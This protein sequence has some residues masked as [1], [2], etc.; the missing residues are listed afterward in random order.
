MSFDFI[1]MVQKGDAAEV[2]R[3]AAIVDVNYQ[4]QLSDGEAHYIGY[5]AMHAAVFHDMSTSKQLTMLPLLV[6]EY[7]ADVD[8][9]WPKVGAPLE[10]AVR[11]SRLSHTDEQQ[12]TAEIQSI[13]NYLI[14]RS[15]VASLKSAMVTATAVCP[16]ARALLATKIPFLYNPT[17]KELDT[18][19]TGSEGFKEQF[20]N[21]GPADSPST[22]EGFRLTTLPSP[23][24]SPA[25]S[26][27]SQALHLMGGFA[28]PGVVTPSSTPAPIFSTTVGTTTYAL[29]ALTS[30]AIITRPTVEAKSSTVPTDAKAEMQQP[31]LMSLAVVSQ[32]PAPVEPIA[33]ARPPA[34]T[35]TNAV[36]LGT[37]SGI[38]TTVA[39][40]PGTPTTSSPAVPT[41]SGCCVIF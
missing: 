33:E 1:K 20:L 34:P 14:D 17:P 7:N 10:Y 19:L 13:I 26:P 27:S 9:V 41:Q 3:L 23:S 12:F 5:S 2:S 37:L 11:L 25:P 31:S 21:F 38:T 29:V 24:S 18:K 4:Q 40:L 32:P 15:S 36:A 39:R 30:N 16:A 22:K 35:A 6:E 28:I 8:V